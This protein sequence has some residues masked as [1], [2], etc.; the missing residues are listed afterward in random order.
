MSCEMTDGHLSIDKV[1]PRVTHGAVVQQLKVSRLQKHLH[2]QLFTH[3][4]GCIKAAPN[5]TMPIQVVD[6]C[7]TA[8]L[9]GAL[10]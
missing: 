3:A 6:F 4:Q 8:H 9:L 5:A 1:A 2:P 10:L 7:K